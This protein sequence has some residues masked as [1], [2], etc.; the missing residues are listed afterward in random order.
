M[1][2]RT[3]SFPGKILVLAALLSPTLAGC[4]GFLGNLGYWAGATVV[5]A[6]YPGLEDQRVAVICVT[7]GSSYG[8]GTEGR[9]LARFV[10]EMLEDQVLEIDIVPAAEIADWI[11]KNDWD[12]VDY[13]EV[14]RG[15]KADRGRHRPGR[16]PAASR[17]GALQGP[18]P[19]YGYGLRHDRRR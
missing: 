1:D 11:D 17:P 6:A 12:S 15:V 13:R 2:G 14:G 10:S 3:R 8:A 7:D 19:G 18:G 4:A 5:P 16:V 9:M